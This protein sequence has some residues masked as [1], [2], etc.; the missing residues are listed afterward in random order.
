MK[1]DVAGRVMVRDACG[2]EG[3]VS[4]LVMVE[5]AGGMKVDVAGCIVAKL[6]RVVVTLGSVVV[7]VVVLLL[8]VFL[9]LQIRPICERSSGSGNEIVSALPRTYESL[10]RGFGRLGT[11]DRL[12]G[13]AF[14]WRS[15]VISCNR[16]FILNQFFT[17]VSLILYS[18]IVVFFNSDS[19]L[20]SRALMM[21]YA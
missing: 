17:V 15:V 4:G 8:L 19:L 7:V 18:V 9:F 16:D 21:L 11:Q 20:K 13:K 2:M 5:E 10:G 3:D 6:A 14:P 12:P 1:V